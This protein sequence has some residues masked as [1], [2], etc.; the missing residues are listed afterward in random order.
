MILDVETFSQKKKTQIP[1][2]K[3]KHAILVCVCVRVLQIIKYNMSE[4]GD[5]CTQL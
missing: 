1:M 2:R 3:A 5:F 4:I